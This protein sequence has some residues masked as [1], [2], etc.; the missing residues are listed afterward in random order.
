LTKVIIIGNAG[1]GKSTLCKTLSKAKGLPINQ[2][3]KLQWNP[4]WVATPQERFNTLH[5]AILKQEKWIIDGVA[6][7]ESIK[8][9]VE[10]ADTIIF[11]DHPL[12]IHYWWA[13]KRQWMCL[14]RDRPDFV[15]GCPMLPKTW[16]LARMIWRIHKQFRP[17]LLALIENHRHD[18]QIFH[19]RSPA[20]LAEF[21]SVHCAIQ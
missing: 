4:G 2:L 5:D 18:K 10:A 17:I 20:E 6:S 3:D 8:R 16:E 21:R 11:I 9:R 19:I 7:V 15:E 14:F 12:W 1:G 13:A